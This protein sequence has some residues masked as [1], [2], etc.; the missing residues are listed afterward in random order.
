M[1]RCSAIE[2]LP[3]KSKGI[4]ENKEGDCFLDIVIQQAAGRRKE[5]RKKKWSLS[6]EIW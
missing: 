2:L 6:H 5:V 4:W 1:Y 3:Q